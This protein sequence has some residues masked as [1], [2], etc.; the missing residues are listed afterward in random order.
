MKRIVLIDGDC[1][2]CNKGVQFIIKRDPNARFQFASL[3]SDIGQQLL[4]EYGVPKSTDSV[5]VIEGDHYFTKSE[6]VLR[7]CKH[8]NGAWKL[9]YTAII[10]P[11]PLRDVYYR[12]IA[13]NRYRWFGR[14]DQCLLLTN[15]MK[16]RFLD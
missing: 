5:V 15:D 13:E 9:L 16:K 4:S 2:V 1:S 8:L 10:I 6:A 3:Q 12:L 7:I 11:K 14:K